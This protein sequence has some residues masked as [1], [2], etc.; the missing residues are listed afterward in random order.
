[1][2]CQGWAQLPPA[3][4]PTPVLSDPRAGA[5]DLMAEV[6]AVVVDSAGRLA[7]D[8]AAADFSVEAGKT[9]KI[10]QCAYVDTR[11]RRTMVFL[12]DDLSLSAEEI[13]AVRAAL[14][15]F[16]DASMQAED[17]VAILRSGGGEGELQQ[18]T[19][20]K[21]ALHQAIGRLYYN[22]RRALYATADARARVFATGPMGALRPALAG[23]RG[24]PGHKRV[25]L[26]SRDLYNRPL[27]DLS[28]MILSAT[29]AGVAFYAIDLAA[30][31]AAQPVREA[32][33]QRAA[34]G[35]PAAPMPVE[36]TSLSLTQLASDAGLAGLAKQT[37]G[38]L[39]EGATALPVSLARALEGPDGYY[40]IGYRADSQNDWGSPRLRVTRP[41]LRLLSFRQITGSASDLQLLG[42]GG[43]GENDL[44]RVLSTPFTAGQIHI[45]ITPLFYDLASGAILDVLVH[46]DVRDLTLRKG[47][48]GVYHGQAEA[49][50][51]EFTTSGQAVQHDQ[52]TI[53]ADW[54][55]AQ[56]QKVRQAGLVASVRLPVRAGMQQIRVVVRDST[57]GRAG[58][59]SQWLDVP[60][61]DPGQLALSGIALDGMEEVPGNDRLQR[62]DPDQTPGVRIFRLGQPF[63][64]EC[65]AYNLTT[66]AAKASRA[67]L[68]IVIFREGR[69]V[70]R[71]QAIP[72][73]FDSTGDL[74]R[75][76]LRG[77]IIASES[78][79]PGRYVLQMSVSDTLAPAGKPRIANQFVELD[80]RE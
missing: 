11:S 34:A 70:S 36:F 66:D 6:E 28:T 26:F 60:A 3:Q 42:N 30:A 78:L 56:Y 24:L 62:K 19:S 73:A 41:G 79:G 57:S 35:S 21:P 14:E 33:P 69:V 59:A 77:R 16:V 75:R 32:T 72:L 38:E 23:L 27:A 20:D 67:D 12:V 43:Q 48:D 50:A 9:V 17:R 71:N 49:L 63:Q 52:M 37:G 46:L 31:A 39:L 2:A 55:E 47:T 18:I 40:R 53:A 76:V 25:V 80:M 61:T 10:A 54:D 44:P 7:A 68:N 45:R 51:S 64:Y 13:D 22:P 4:A 74:K 8:L 1:M 58:W 29:R 65:I 15:K 5:R